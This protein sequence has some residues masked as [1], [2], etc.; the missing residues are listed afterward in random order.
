MAKQK[1]SKVSAITKSWQECKA[2][3]IGTIFKK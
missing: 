2:A 1:I 3:E